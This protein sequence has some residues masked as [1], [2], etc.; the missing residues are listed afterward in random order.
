MAMSRFEFFGTKM[1]VIDATIT[2][3]ITI[4]KQHGQLGGRIPYPTV[5]VCRVS[6]D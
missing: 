1:G 6:L 3:D 5:Q 2:M 4:V